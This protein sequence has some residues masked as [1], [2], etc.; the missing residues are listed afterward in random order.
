MRWKV[1]QAK[2]KLSEV[3][4]CAEAEPQEI[5]NRDRVVAVVLGAKDMKAFRNWQAE[6]DPSLAEA[7]AE[8]RRICAEEDYT[9]PVE[10]RRDRDNAVL[11]VT[12]AGRHKR[13]Q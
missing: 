5:F 6:R 13:R 4:R 2:Q 12:D 9:L 8:A 1:A 10:P 7:L 11:Q 3:L